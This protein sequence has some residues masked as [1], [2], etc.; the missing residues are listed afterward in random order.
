MKGGKSSNGFRFVENEE[1]MTDVIHTTQQNF[2]DKPFHICTQTHTHTN[3]L[4][5]NT[6]P[7]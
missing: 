5:N 4:R 2:I 7:R 3:S 6:V 1:A